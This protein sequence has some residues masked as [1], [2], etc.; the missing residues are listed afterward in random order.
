MYNVAMC[1]YIYNRVLLLVL[2]FF[3][4][5]LWVFFLF[6]F[7]CLFDFFFICFVFYLFFSQS[8]LNTIKLKSKQ[9]G[10]NN[11][12]L[13]IIINQ[14]YNIIISVADQNRFSKWLDNSFRH[15]PF[16]LLIQCAVYRY[17]SRLYLLLYT[18]KAGHLYGSSFTF[19]Y[20]I[21]VINKN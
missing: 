18:L 8:V 17:K 15:S 11:N 20:F 5:F 4:L 6:V 14:L 9:S 21:Y 16:K 7:C 2:C 12:Y 19:I 3:L 13:K 1:M 10:T